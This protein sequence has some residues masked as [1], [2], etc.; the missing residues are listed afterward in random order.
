KTAEWI[1]TSTRNIQSD[2]R[3]R[4]GRTERMPDCVRKRNSRRG[5][6]RTD[7]RIHVCGNAAGG[8]QLVERARPR[9]SR[10]DEAVLPF[11]AGERAGAGGRIAECASGHVA[12]QALE[13]AFLLG[14]IHPSRRVAV[15]SSNLF[16]TSRAAF[17]RAN[18]RA[19]T[20][21]RS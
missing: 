15:S 3:R 1:L 12:G 4:I 17:G 11:D 5:T 18:R 13:F 2:A 8:S 6:P 19:L 10:V 21:M 7:A 16:T 9:D 20:C 14:W